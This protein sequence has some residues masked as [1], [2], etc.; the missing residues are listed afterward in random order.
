MASLSSRNDS[1][2]RKAWRGREVPN[3][4]FVH[5]PWPTRVS[6]RCFAPL[7][8]RGASAGRVASAVAL[9]V[10]KPSVMKPWPPHLAELL[11]A[12]LIRTFADSRCTL[13]GICASPAGVHQRQ[14]RRR[15]DRR[16]ADC[17]MVSGGANAAASGRATRAGRS[18]HPSSGCDGAGTCPALASR[19][20]TSIPCSRATSRTWLKAC[21]TTPRGPPLSSPPPRCV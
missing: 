3:R 12:L 8:R 6:I 11:R 9:A 10:S 14:G 19:P 7:N 15:N 1:A 17:L 2:K 20:D 5:D 18:R 21:A 13:F 16:A 4:R